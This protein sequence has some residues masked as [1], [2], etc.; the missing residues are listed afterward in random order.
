MALMQDDVSVARKA[1]MASPCAHLRRR[2]TSYLIG[3]NTR[4]AVNEM[5]L[6]HEE[7]L[8]AL[9]HPRDKETTGS[10]LDRVHEILIRNREDRD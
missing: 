1:L 4:N 6:R 8:D 3:R 7:A 2:Y 9:A 5:L 10:M